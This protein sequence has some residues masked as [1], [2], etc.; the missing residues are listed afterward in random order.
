MLKKLL[1][2]GCLLMVLAPVQASECTIKTYVWYCDMYAANPCVAP[3]WVS[4]IN[5]ERL[6]DKTNEECIERAL[7]KKQIYRTNPA[8]GR[9]FRKVVVKY[10]DAT[11]DA[12]IRTVIR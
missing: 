7:E 10:T 8:S 3:I 5:K 4:P 12:S 9:H 2:L 1:V 11:R 6:F